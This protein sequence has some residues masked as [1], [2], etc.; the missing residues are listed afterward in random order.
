MLPDL[1]IP[2]IR[3][4]IST[5]WPRECLE[6]DFSKIQSKKQLTK[7][8]VVSGRIIRALQEKGS[9]TI[10]E[11]AECGQCDHKRAYDIVNVFQAVGF[12]KEKNKG[13][14][15]YN[16]GWTRSPWCNGTHCQLAVC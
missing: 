16:I 8:T 15:Q 7:L 6:P 3:H 10:D 2:E 12:I 14:K 1:E 13:T 4:E 5:K 9:L 11:I